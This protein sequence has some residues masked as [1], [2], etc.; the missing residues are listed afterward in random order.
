MQKKSK[1]IKNDH[2]RYTFK[3]DE[4]QINCNKTKVEVLWKCLGALYLSKKTVTCKLTILGNFQNMQTELLPIIFICSLTP[5]TDIQYSFSFPYLQ[6]QYESD[7]LLSR[8]RRY[9]PV[10]GGVTFRITFRC[11]KRDSTPSWKVATAVNYDSA[12]CGLPENILILVLKSF[13]ILM[14]TWRSPSLKRMYSERGLGKYISEV[15]WRLDT[16]LG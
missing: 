4:R 13:Q 7:S 8:R 5:R 1:F 15:K 11:C 12:K 10:W 16:W 6:K 2:T 3:R 14:L 9:V